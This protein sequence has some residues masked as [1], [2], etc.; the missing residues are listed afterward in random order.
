MDMFL[1]LMI[2]SAIFG[3][4]EWRSQRRE[5]SVKEGKGSKMDFNPSLKSFPSFPVFQKLRNLKLNKNYTTLF[6]KFT[7]EWNS[8]AWTN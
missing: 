4:H 7:P 5:R 6:C 3:Q 1:K 8:V 2:V